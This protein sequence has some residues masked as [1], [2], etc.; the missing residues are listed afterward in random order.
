MIHT[1]HIRVDLDAIAGNVRSIQT[2]VGPSATVCPVIKADAYGLGAVRVARTMISAGVQRLAVFTLQQAIEL[3][4]TASHARILVLMPVKEIPNDPAI[5]RLIASGRLELVVSEPTQVARLAATRLGR[6]LSVH[7]EVD[8]G[9]GRGGVSVGDA[10]SL[11]REIM[12]RR[13]MKLVG[14][15]THFSSS[16]PEQVE[17]EAA[18]FD[19]F[20]DDVRELLPA[21]VIRHAAST[22]PCFSAP[23]QRRDMVRIGLGWAGWLPTE[24]ESGSAPAALRPAVTWCSRLAQVRE[25]PAGATVGYGSNWQASEA[26]TVGLVPVGYAHGYPATR[27]DSSDPHMV[28]VAINDGYR[29]VPVIGA[30]SMDQLMIDLGGVEGFDPQRD[31]EVILLSDQ[32]DSVV[33]LHALSRRAGLPPHAVLS[34]LAAS[35]PR[36]YL[37][38]ATSCGA[39]TSPIRI[40]EATSGTSSM[41][42]G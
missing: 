1:S 15:F 12:S 21:R 9:M 39:G 31:Q 23:A 16:T 28:L 35:I 26:T 42:A 37:A 25:L 5:A 40:S 33:G 19:T 7:L 22:G 8:C 14:V 4:S 41:A 32:A 29:A 36:V 30:V 3:E 13:S 24:S 34:T 17:L 11:I 27:T 20:L 6:S 2:A 38:D 18:R 10:P